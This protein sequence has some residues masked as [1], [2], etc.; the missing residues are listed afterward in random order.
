MFTADISLTAG[1]HQI[2]VEYYENGGHAVARV[3]WALAP[4]IIYNW[5]GEY[6]NNRWLSG[7][8]AFVRDDTNIAFNWGYGSPW[9]LVSDNFSVRWTRTSTLN[10]ALIASPLL[11]MMV[12]ACGSMGI[13]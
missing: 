1:H 8:P 4:T 11:P 5:H 6:F 3:S 12:C 10:P 9:L 7:T 2:V 13:C